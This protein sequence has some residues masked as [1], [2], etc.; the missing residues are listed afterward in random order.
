MDLS[1]YLA[2]MEAELEAMRFHEGKTAWL[3]CKLSSCNSGISF[4]PTK[5]DH[6]NMLVLTD[7]TPPNNHDPTEVAQELISAAQRIGCEKILLDFQ[8]E[9]TELSLHIIQKI[10]ER[11]HIPVGVAAEHAEEFNCA[12]FLSPPPLWTPL[13]EALQSWKN[14][15]IWLE[16]APESGCITITEDASIYTATPSRGAYPLYDN[17]MHLSYRTQID[18]RTVKVYLQ[19]STD[20][21]LSWLH[22]AQEAG[23]RTAIGLY[24]L[25][26]DF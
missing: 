20:H 18:D 10:L 8:R 11:T 7:E 19:R 21:I 26:P 16:I 22:H 17:K 2:F 6:C 15:E 23:I 5:I 12:V 14:R 13:C 3:G 9:P 25:L 1:I 4:H 24:G